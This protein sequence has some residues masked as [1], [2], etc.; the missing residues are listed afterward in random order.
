M[1]SQLE[2]GTVST[3]KDA[4]QLGVIVSQCFN[5]QSPNGWQ[6]YSNRIGLEN[7]RVIRQAGQIIGGL[8]IYQMGQWYGG[9]CV[10]MA[11][12][13]SVGVA[14]EH[15]GTGVGSEPGKTRNP[16]YLKVFVHLRGQWCVE[17]SGFY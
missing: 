12:I 13:A 15:R 3:P 14:P 9:E 1:T 6:T 16:Y 2:Y 10:P 11:G 5:D 7:F 17:G 8:S 4:Q